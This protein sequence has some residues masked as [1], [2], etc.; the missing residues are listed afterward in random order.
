LSPSSQPPGG[1]RHHHHATSSAH[2]SSNA[3]AH[4]SN[5]NLLSEHDEHEPEEPVGLPSL[6]D[7]QQRKERDAGKNVVTYLNHMSIV[8]EKSS[9]YLSVPLKRI[10]NC[11]QAESYQTNLGPSPLL[12]RLPLLATHYHFRHQR[13]VE[14]SVP[15]SRGQSQ[16]IKTIFISTKSD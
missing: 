8:F 5:S 10:R 12:C 6:P 14:S 4:A 11:L 16:E 3:P 2:P 15:L 1:G 9:V 13:G 7:P